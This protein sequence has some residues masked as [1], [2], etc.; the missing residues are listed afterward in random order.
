MSNFVSPLF[1]CLCW[2]E[3]KASTDVAG[4]DKK[5]AS[6]VKIDKKSFS[7]Q[8]KFLSSVDGDDDH[9]DDHDGDD[10]HDS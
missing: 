9:D 1:V 3:E 2:I 6:A 7:D 4:Q 8:E 5:S 10:D